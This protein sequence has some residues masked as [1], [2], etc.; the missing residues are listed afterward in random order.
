MQIPRTIKKIIKDLFGFNILLLFREL[1]VEFKISWV[2]FKN[3]YFFI[4]KSLLEK[5]GIKL[6]IGCGSSL[7]PGFV[8]IDLNPIADI[9]LDIRKNLPFKDSSVSYIYSEHFF[10]HVDYIHLTAYYM[11]K[12]WLRVLLPGAKVKIVLPDYEM[13]FTQYVN[14]NYD[15]FKQQV[16]INE[17]IPKEI[18]ATLIDYVNYG[19]YQFGEHKYCYDFEKIKVFL[20]AVGFINVERVHF[21]DGEDSPARKSVSMYIIA[22]K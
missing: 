16:N 18:P 4:E 12:D 3:R 8:N 9:K 6:N 20:E 7:R 10:E 17:K 1:L 22:N 19:V 13:L 14:R 11:L 15:L 2:D 21:E 5:N